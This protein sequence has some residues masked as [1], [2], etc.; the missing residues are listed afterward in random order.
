MAM[1]GLEK[2]TQRILSQ[3]QEEADRIISEAEA[4]AAELAP[5]SVDIDEGTEMD[6]AEAD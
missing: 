5:P 2:I 4:E 6:A 3:A 1:N